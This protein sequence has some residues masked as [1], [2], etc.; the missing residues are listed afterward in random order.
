MKE[1][2]PEKTFQNAVTMINSG[3][4]EICNNVKTLLELI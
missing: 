3:S 1:S 2:H 4:Y